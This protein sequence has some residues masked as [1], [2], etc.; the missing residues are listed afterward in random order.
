MK[1]TNTAQTEAPEKKSVADPEVAP[2][3]EPAP[4]SDADNFFSVSSKDREAEM[5]KYMQELAAPKEKM[6]DVEL[7]FMDDPDDPAGDPQMTREEQELAG[8]LDVS[9]GHKE[10][11]RVMLMGI[12]KF[13]AFIASMITGMDMDRYKRSKNPDNYEVEVTAAMMKKYEVQMS[14]EW[15][16]AVMMIGAYSPAF[17]KAYA[18]HKAMKAKREKERR[19]EELRILAQNI[20]RN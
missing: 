3:A 5:K 10:M 8:Y 12:D 20:H 2:K 1:K 19:Q 6:D 4:I 7:E 16:F 15:M 18:D 13:L 17:Q 9:D 14:L 11:A